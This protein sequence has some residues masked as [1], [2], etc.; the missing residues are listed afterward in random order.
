METLFHD[1]FGKLAIGNI[2]KWPYG[3]E[4][5]YH[6][7]TDGPD[8]GHWEEA[9][10]TY[11]W[12][13]GTGCWKVFPE[14]GQHVMEQTLLIETDSPLLV[15]GSRFWGDYTLSADVR[16]LSWV[17]PLG[18][19]VRYANSR[20]YYFLSIG[21]E[22][23]SFVLRDHER[24]VVLGSA[25][26]HGDVLRYH[27][28]AVACQ[29]YTL[30]ASIDG[31]HLLTVTD[32]AA[33]YS[34]GRVGLLAEAPA[35]FG[36]V[37]VEADETS[38]AQAR[39]RESAWQAAE[40]TL[41]AHQPKPILWRRFETPGYG[42]D[43]NLRYGDLNGDGRIEIVIPQGIHH[44]RGDAFP[45]INCLTA[46]D[47]DGHVLWQVGEPISTKPHMT[48]DLC[49][50]VYDWDGDGCA[51]VIC[52]MGFYLTV[53]DGK[54]GQVRQRVPMPVDEALRENEPY[55]RSFGDSICFCDLQGLGARRNLVIKDRYKTIWAYDNA[56]NLL[57]SRELNTG[58][59]P[60]PYDVDGDG[61]EEL[62]VGYSLLGSDGSLL[63]EI[64]LT[65]HM[66]GA[67][68]GRLD[69]S[70]A[71]IRVAMGCSDEGFV[72]ADAD[73][74]VL[75]HELRGHCQGANIARL[76]PGRH[77]LQI[78]TIT[79]WHHPGIITIWDTQGRILSE[80]EPLQIG[81]ILPPVDWAANGTA[82]LL[83]NTHP[84][85]GG[86]MDA[87]GHRVVMFPD[88]GHPVLC[89]DATDLDGD[90]HQ[91]IITW[92][93]DGIWLYRADPLGLSAAHPADMTPIYNNSNYRSR[94]LIPV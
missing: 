39:A 18:L 81:S 12:R 1:D 47:L 45:M 23:I 8:T 40:R 76:L 19:V 34:C 66:D 50:Q 60:V 62:L 22:S 88:D 71:P 3:P 13:Q 28:V 2:S 69:G 61:R 94:W 92:D 25:P 15:T 49:A 31:Q 54:T 42:T 64:E 77:D 83:H 72:L 30:R 6:V 73:G 56:L 67:Y 20:R 38:A 87:H 27:H 24:E 91:E 65:D 9:N 58:H 48:G 44:G 41:Q 59:Y 78:A 17:R 4:G 10:I 36:D 14:D 84:H 93:W 51:E 75:V 32:E 57:W 82:L 55:A 33:T 43:R 35:R 80:F 37:R 68:I 11:A 74:R 46:V 26:W 53:L 52:V 7:M 29:G 89:C 85:T 16:A 70:D 5:E 79:F 90:G 21:R 63:W 86:M